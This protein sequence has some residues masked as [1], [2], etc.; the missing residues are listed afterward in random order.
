MN[1]EQLDAIAAAEWPR[2]RDVQFVPPECLGYEMWRLTGD[3]RVCVLHQLYDKQDVFRRCLVTNADWPAP[4]G[5]NYPTGGYN[6]DALRLMD[7]VT[8]KEDWQDN[9]CAHFRELV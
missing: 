5:T 2:L 7:L 1:R 8:D 9:L 3:Y 6:K 4:P